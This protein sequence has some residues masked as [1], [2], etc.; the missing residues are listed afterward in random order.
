M[1]EEKLTSRMKHWSELNDKEKTER[2]REQVKTLQYQVRKLENLVN[3]LISH[4]HSDGGP[5]T[6]I[7]D[8]EH[9]GVFMNRML[10]DQEY[11]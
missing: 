3:K 4:N 2:A 9:G 8:E 10:K 11:F 6:P 5:L 1:P 7:E